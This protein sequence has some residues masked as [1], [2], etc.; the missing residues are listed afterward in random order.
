MINNTLLTPNTQPQ[1]LSGVNSSGAGEGAISYLAHLF[2]GQHNAHSTP[3][4]SANGPS[5]QLYDLLHGWDSIFTMEPSWMREAAKQIHP[6]SEPGRDWVALARRL[7]YSPRD[8]YRLKLEDEQ[9]PALALLRD[10]FDSNGRT[11]YCIDILMSCLRMISR[12]D[13]FQMLESELEPEGSAPPVFISYQSA[14]QE[15]ALHLRRRLELSGFPCWMDVGLLRGGDQLY[16]RIYEGLSRCK[17][18]ICCLTARYCASRSCA[19]EVTLADVLHKPILPIMLE[20]TPWPPPGPMALIMSS[21]VY[22]DLCG[23]GGHG[24]VGKRADHESRFREILDKVARY[25]A[26]YVDV[27]PLNRPMLLPDL[28]QQMQMPSQRSIGSD[29]SSTALGISGLSGDEMLNDRS[30]LPLSALYAARLSSANHLLY[31]PSAMLLEDALDIEPE[32]NISNDQPSARTTGEDHE[33]RDERNTQA[34]SATNDQ[35]NSTLEQYDHVNVESDREHTQE[36]SATQRAQE[37][38][39]LAAPVEVSFG[40]TIFLITIDM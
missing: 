36:Q 16:T 37:S 12:E 29:V 9:Y 10:W 3:S 35:Q 13:V 23:V 24:G 18:V 5:N 6:R 21:L 31:G 33:N 19:R 40:K 2:S 25:V 32:D 17:L 4:I 38:N 30:D 39:A 8:T 1:P 34:N 22:V 26:G 15:A 27:P 14:S 20:P 28:F 7:G 11:R